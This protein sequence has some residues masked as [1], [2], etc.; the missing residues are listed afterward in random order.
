MG[1][2]FDFAALLPYAG[3]FAH[4]LLNT[5][6]YAAL[7]IFFGLLIGAVGALTLVYAQ[8]F[9]RRL[10]RCYVEFFRNTPSLVQLFIIYF[11]FPNLGLRLD[12]PTAAVISLSL[13][14][15]SYMTEILRSGLT[16][17][18]RGLTEA[19]EALGLGR[20]HIISHIL[21][22]PALQNIF[23]ALASQMVLTLIGTSL[24]SQ[25]GVE[26]IFHTGSL[27]ESRTFRSFEIY[28]LICG[29]YFFAVSCM[30]LIL[31]ALYSR[32]QARR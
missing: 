20:R 21:A 30:K 10:A 25:I 1:Y 5:S 26:E 3:E 32:F 15:G 12:A 27:V 11:G 17:L 28:L 23:P 14:S 6:R 4:G 7:S 9:W 22:L 16:S 8:P 31:R 19:G 2:Q 18:P 24:I 29:L 13:Y